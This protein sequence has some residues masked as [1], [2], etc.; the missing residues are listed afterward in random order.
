MPSRLGTSYQMHQTGWAIATAP[1]PAPALSEIPAKWQFW[2]DTWLPVNSGAHLAQV[3]PLAELQNLQDYPPAFSSCRAAHLAPHSTFHFLRHGV[4]PNSFHSHSCRGGHFPIAVNSPLAADVVWQVVATAAVSEAFPFEHHILG[5]SLYNHPHLC[6][7]PQHNHLPSLGTARCPHPPHA[8]LWIVRLWV[9]RSRQ[10]EV[11]R[12]I[13]QRLSELVGPLEVSPL[14]AFPPQF[15][16][17][18]ARRASPQPLLIAPPYSSQSVAHHPVV[19]TPPYTEAPTPAAIHPVNAFGH[20]FAEQHVPYSP[21]S[22]VPFPSH[23]HVVVGP[24]IGTRR[25]SDNATWM[26]QAVRETHQPYDFYPRQYPLPCTPPVRVSPSVVTSS[27]YS[28]RSSSSME[29]PDEA[30][31]STPPLTP[32]SGPPLCTFYFPARSSAETAPSATRTSGYQHENALGP[33]HDNADSSVAQEYYE[34]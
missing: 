5:V 7:Q 14:S 3:Q 4:D 13:Q 2:Q 28:R 1:I 6:A 17:H 12:Q 20:S 27:P 11:I 21:A 18:A 10:R 22:P 15:I 32:T 16:P 24:P 8:P 31:S 9:K 29:F 33:I 19:S 26:A 30:S 23:Q 34:E 25:N